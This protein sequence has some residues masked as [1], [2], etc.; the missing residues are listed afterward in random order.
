MTAESTIG[1][2]ERK[3]SA[4]I[5]VLLTKVFDI[6]KAEKADAALGVLLQNNN[7][8]LSTSL[9]EWLQKY[10]DMEDLAEDASEEVMRQRKEIL[11]CCI[12]TLRAWLIDPRRAY[13]KPYTAP[14]EPEGEPKKI[15]MVQVL[16][17][18]RRI[19]S[20]LEWMNVKVL[21]KPAESLP[22]SGPL[23]QKLIEDPSNQ[24]N[25][26][27]ATAIMRYIVIVGALQPYVATPEKL[28][29]AMRAQ[30]LDAVTKC[31]ASLREWM[32]KNNVTL[33]TA[34]QEAEI[35]ARLVAHVKAERDARTKL[36]NVTKA[37]KNCMGQLR[38]LAIC[39]GVEQ[40]S[41]EAWLANYPGDLAKDASAALSAY[42]QC[43]NAMRQ[44][45]ANQQLPDAADEAEFIAV[46]EKVTELGTKFFDQE[47][48]KVN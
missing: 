34:D 18:Q 14:A 44:K 4:L 30:A 2:N 45:E 39:L 42:K 41:V 7:E 11:D 23:V 9:C 20:L 19:S 24:L 29:D 32:T 17:V 26:D 8:P 31:E 25:M 16:E 36:I 46:S 1:M 35:S 10:Q 13:F 5:S 6:Q 22:E 47:K 3:K 28:S 37:M 12:D 38:A 15:S 48:V 21:N 33:P 27:L 43:T 40:G